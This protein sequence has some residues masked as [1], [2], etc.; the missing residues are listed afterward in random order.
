MEQ[1]PPMVVW[2][3]ARMGCGVHHAAVIGISVM[4]LF[5]ADNLDLSMKVYNARYITILL[6]N[7]SLLHSLVKLWKLQKCLEEEEL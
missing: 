4:H 6:S 1:I 3:F 7:N 5:C 2:R